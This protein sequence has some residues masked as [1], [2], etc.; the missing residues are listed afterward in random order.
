MTRRKTPLQLALAAYAQEK[1]AYE[2]EK[3]GLSQ[4]IDSVQKEI[5]DLKQRIESLYRTGG[6]VT[7]ELDLSKSKETALQKLVILQTRRTKLGD[8]YNLEKLAAEA[9]QLA[10]QVSA[11]YYNEGMGTVEKALAD[12][13]FAYLQ[14]VV[15]YRMHKLKARDIVTEAARNVD[16]YER[17]D[18]QNYPYY[19][20]IPVLANGYRSLY[21]LHENEVLRAL[22]LGRIEPES[23]GQ[24]RTRES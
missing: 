11:D 4:E 22:N 15:A 1:S 8:R 2:S 10:K 20:E 24:E 9:L 18:N 12:A 6:T 17:L 13:K 7:E 21:N 16:R 23:C 14:A 19:R 5:T 3:N